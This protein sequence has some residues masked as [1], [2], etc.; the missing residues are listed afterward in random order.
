MTPSQ[1]LMAP[2]NL[3]TLV[4]LPYLAAIVKGVDGTSC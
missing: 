3:S 1:G 2:A 4:R